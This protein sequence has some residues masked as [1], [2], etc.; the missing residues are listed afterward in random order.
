MAIRIG[1][2]FPVLV[3]RNKTAQEWTVESMD[4]NETVKL[5]VRSNGKVLVTRQRMHLVDL[6]VKAHNGERFARG[7]GA[8]L[9]RRR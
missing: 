8:K 6:M 1:D 5:R 2:V 3:G 7:N 9:E 4:A